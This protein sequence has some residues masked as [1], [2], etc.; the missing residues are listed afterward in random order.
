[1]GVRFVAGVVAKLERT[2][3]RRVLLLSLGGLLYTLMKG[4]DRH[5]VVVVVVIYVLECLSRWG[6]EIG[7][8]E[9]SS[10]FATQFRGS[11]ESSL[12]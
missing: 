4:T 10:S 1:M 11:V 8:D 5:V 3:F 6:L 7:K 12:F 9:I 2:R